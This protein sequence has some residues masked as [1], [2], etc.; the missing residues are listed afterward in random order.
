[1]NTSRDELS[2]IPGQLSKNENYLYMASG[3]LRERGG[4]A[5]LSSAPSAGNQI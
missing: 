3:G 5:R 2:L 1:M 4:G